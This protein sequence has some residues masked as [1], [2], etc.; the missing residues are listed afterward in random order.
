MET[1]VI[2]NCLTEDLCLYEIC[3]KDRGIRY[4]VH[5]AYLDGAF[6]PLDSFD[7]FIVGGTPISVYDAHRYDF[8]RKEMVYLEKVVKKGKPYLGICAGAQLLARL[9]GAEVCRNPVVEIGSYCVKLTPTGK[10]S[11]F[12]A[13][14]P[15]A[16][17]VFQWHGDTFTIPEGGKL[18]VKGTSCKNQAFSYG[19]SLGV[20]FHLEL[21]SEAV[22]RWAVQ[23]KDELKCAG[24][25]KKEIVND[26]R[27]NERKMAALAGKLIDNF[28]NRAQ[29]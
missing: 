25:M 13:G 12:F 21:T 5:R 11:R 1:L 28:F 23:Y 9:L 4:R 29:L 26:C 10:T 14:F 8:M 6:P 20:Q 22:N 18:L 27:A 16:F 2:Q 24:K 19:N 15:A 3:L 7:A 17:P